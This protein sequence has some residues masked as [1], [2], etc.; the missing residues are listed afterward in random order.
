MLPPGP[1]EV[2]EQF[3]FAGY[4]VEAEHDALLDIVWNGGD[5]EN[6]DAVEGV[7]DGGNFVAQSGTEDDD[8]DVTGAGLLREIGGAGE[9]AMRSS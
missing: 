1:R 4:D 8:G 5:G 2:D 6:V 3:R 9:R 7:T